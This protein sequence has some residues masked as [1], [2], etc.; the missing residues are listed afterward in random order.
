ML[1]RTFS[2]LVQGCG[3]TREDKGATPPEGAGSPKKHGMDSN[4]PPNVQP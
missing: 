1:K 2:G 3:A 4:G